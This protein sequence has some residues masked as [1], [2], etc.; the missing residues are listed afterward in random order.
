MRRSAHALGT[1]SVLALVVGAAPAGA[2]PAPMTPARLEEMAEAVVVGKI[3]STTLIKQDQQGGWARA[4]Y[5]SA[6]TVQ[7]VSK[8]TL[9]PGQTIQ[10]HWFNESWVGKGIHPVGRT[11]AAVFSLCEVVQLYL[12]RSG[13]GYG[14]AAWNGRHTLVQPRSAPWPDAKRR[15]VR[16]PGA[17]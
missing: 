6:V 5:T 4:M 13:D 11:P 1:L 2:I 3:V 16:C 14:L 17:R 8:G 9:R 12:R 7:K 15:T 10:L